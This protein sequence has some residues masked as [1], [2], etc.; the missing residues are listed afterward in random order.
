[1]QRS[2]RLTSVY[3]DRI[4]LVETL[5]EVKDAIGEWHDWEE[6]ASIAGEVLEHGSRCGLIAKLKEVASQKYD[7]A[8]SMTSKM[9][10]RFVRARD[11]E[12]TDPVLM[13]KAAVS[14]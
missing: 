3:A 7:Q 5:G 11:G 14:S 6:L 4:A 12:K 10:K 13:A 8:L 2:G 1:M 9:R